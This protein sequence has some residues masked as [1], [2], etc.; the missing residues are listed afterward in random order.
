[1]VRMCKTMTLACAT[2]LVAGSAAHAADVAAKS[3]RIVS[4]AKAETTKVQAQSKTFRQV[5]PATGASIFGAGDPSCNCLGWDNGS[6]DNVDGQASHL[7][8][9]IP[10]GAMAADDFYLCEGQVHQLRSVS[11]FLIT[12]SIPAL[13]KAKAILW[14]DCNGCPKDE[15]YTFTEFEPITAA[16]SLGNGFYLVE[17]KFVMANQFEDDE[18][19]IVLHGG[20]YWLSLVG[21]TDNQCL[22]M[23]MC[24]I[25]FFATTGNGTVKGS[26]ARKIDGVPTGNWGQYSFLSSCGGTYGWNPVDNCCIGCTDLAFT[27]CADPCKVLIDNGSQITQQTASGGAQSEKSINNSSRNTRAADDFVINPCSDFRVCYIEGCIYTNCDN[28]TGFFE[29]YRNDCKLPDFYFGD[30]PVAGSDSATKVVDLGFSVT[31][32]GTPNLRAYRV[33]FHNL[34]FILA[35]GYSYWIS[36]GAIDTFSF[37]ERAYFCCNYDC[38]R[39]GC[40]TRF[41]RGVKLTTA[42]QGSHPSSPVGWVDAGCDFAFKIAG[43]YLT[44]RDGSGNSGTACVADIDASGDVTPTDLFTFLD[45]WFTGC[46]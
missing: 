5:M 8:G 43:D 24:D 20:V 45:A 6:W 12:N 27:I 21:K 18:K 19:S 32:N 10:D 11:G 26:V 30:T 14:S 29:I 46:P 44:I 35:R 3:A 33:E 17:Y 2:I 13:R 9:G 7:G 28:F 38:R 37:T 36:V 16:Q 4:N 40:L 42:Q 15:L 1:M 23:N 39:L 22:T 34:S 25:S 31:I 41:N